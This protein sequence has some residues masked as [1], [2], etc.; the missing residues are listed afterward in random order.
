M[1]RT[2]N[3]RKTPTTSRADEG[4]LRLV[5]PP[6][7]TAAEQSTGLRFVE[8]IRVSTPGQADRDTA[9]IQSPRVV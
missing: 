8:M 5:M 6:L 7:I 1:A 4:G 2:K 9:E 3:A